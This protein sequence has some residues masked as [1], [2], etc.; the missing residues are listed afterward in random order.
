MSSRDEISGFALLP[1]C[2]IP[3]YWLDVGE[4]VAQAARDG[5]GGGDGRVMGL[6]LTAATA[7][8]DDATVV[9]PVCAGCE[10]VWIGRGRISSRGR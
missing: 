4:W 10:T 7:V 1:P 8:A 5:G 2:F 6:F 3:N 9:L